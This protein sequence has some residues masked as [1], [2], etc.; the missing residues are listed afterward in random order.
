LKA[1]AVEINGEIHNDLLLSG[2]S[3]TLVVRLGKKWKRV[4]V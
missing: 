4:R 2:V 3:G 1:G